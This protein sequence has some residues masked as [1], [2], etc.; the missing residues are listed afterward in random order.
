MA[1]VI[2]NSIKQPNKSGS[3]FTNL[4]RF[5][6]VNK[7]NR[8]GQSIASGV[9]NVATGARNALGQSQQQFQQKAE[10]NRLD[11][12]ANSQRV[13]DVLNQAPEL[14]GTGPNRNEEQ[15]KNL[16]QFTQFREGKYSG[17]Q[18]LQDQQALQARAQE[19]QQLGQSTGTAGGRIGLLQRF[20]GGNK[21]NYGMGAQS[22]DSMLLERQKDPLAQARR[23]T[24]S[25]GQEVQ[26]GQE[27]ARLYAQN[28]GQKAQQ[29][30]QKTLE[31]LT[32]KTQEVDKPLQELLANKEK[33]EQER[34]WAVQDIKNL[35]GMQGTQDMY[36]PKTGKLLRKGEAFSG[37]ESDAITKALTLAGQ[38]GF[39]S[40]AGLNRLTDIARKTLTPIERVIEQTTQSGEKGLLGYGGAAKG[41]TYT[42]DY[43]PT[44]SGLNIRNLMKDYLLSQDAGNINRAGLSDKQQKAQLNALQALAGSKEEFSDLSDYGYK[45]GAA[46]FD[47]DAIDRAVNERI[48]SLKNQKLVGGTKFEETP[49][50]ERIR[51]GLTPDSQEVRTDAAQDMNKILS[52]GGL[53][54]V[55]SGAAGLGLTNVRSG[56]GQQFNPAFQGLNSVQQGLSNPNMLQGALDV[57]TGLATG[58][59]RNLSAGNQTNPVIAG[60]LDASI[61]KAGL[62]SG[63]SD[64]ASIAP[65]SMNA[66]SALSP[67]AQALSTINSINQGIRSISNAKNFGDVVSGVGSVVASPVVQAAQGFERVGGVIRKI[68]V[69]GGA[70]GGAAQSV[71]G[72]LKKLFSDEELKHNIHSADFDIKKMLDKLD[73]KN[74]DYKNP[75]HG[76]GR[77]TG[78][79]AQDL[80]KSSLGKRFVENTDEGKMVDYTKMGETML[81]GQ[82][83]LNKRLNKIESLLNKK[84]SK[85]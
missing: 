50:L 29:F 4:Q 66:L 71:G 40:E 53:G 37:G 42:Y 79:I 36:D 39:V 61:N 57:G 6:D 35:L 85:E 63:L 13:K 34:S 12:D 27:A 74:Y 22:L 60:A 30:G 14:V 58:N 78:I 81:A 82:V 24:Q 41:Q 76:E 8:L 55:A 47:I 83:H 52:A 21:G 38:Q 64:A 51:R 56:L 16:R 20:A 46:G 70:I 17:P 62:P 9:Q 5:L 1:Q 15:Q 7:Q 19:G 43:T 65:S 77:R 69:I 49:M 73:A 28:L 32:G 18:E 59:T 80:E 44:T 72:F 84:D 67:Q 68:P 11:T 31:Q 75:A 25:L 54:D 10:S 23:Q 48:A 3:G 2:D 26:S 45:A 33:E